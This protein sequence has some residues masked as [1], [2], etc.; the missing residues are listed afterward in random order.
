MKGIKLPKEFKMVLYIIKLIHKE[1]ANLDSKN[2][3]EIRELKNSV[4]GKLFSKD[5]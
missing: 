5:V 4:R 2:I 1:G 3:D